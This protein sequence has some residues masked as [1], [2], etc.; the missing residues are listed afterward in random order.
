M[1]AEQTHYGK[2]ARIGCIVCLLFHGKKVP[3][4]IHH[5]RFPAGAGQKATYK[6]TK[7]LC[8]EHHTDGG[9]GIAFHAGPRA[10]EKNYRT[11]RELLRYVERLMGR[12]PGFVDEAF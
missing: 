4:Q 8:P 6:E 3:A 7:G 5:C 9:Y 1:T 12:E 11:E 2:V 10:F